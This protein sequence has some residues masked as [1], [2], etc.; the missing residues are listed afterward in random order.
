MVDI[1]TKEVRVCN[2]AGRPIRPLF[3]VA[4]GTREET[5]ADPTAWQEL[6]IR[7]SHCQRLQDPS[8]QYTFGSLIQDGLVE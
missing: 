1:T 2:D 4:E 5:A 7:H 8:D 6:L 3:I